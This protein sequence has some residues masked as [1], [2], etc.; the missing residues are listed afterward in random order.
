MDLD[1]KRILLSGATGGL[2]QA[3]AQELADA[4]AELVLSSRREKELQEIAAGL[5]G[6]SHE[7]I[8]ADLSKRGAAVK[9]IADAGDIDGLIA[10]AAMPATGRMEELTEDQ[11][12]RALIV[13]F[14]SPIL[15]THALVPALRKKG[16]GHL[17]YVASLAGHAAS[18]RSSLYS[19]T[20]FG[21]RGYAFGLRS[22][23][24]PDGVGVSVVSPGFV[25]DAG[26]F[27]D[28]GAAPPP[29]MGTT[30]PKKVGS[31]VRKAIERNSVER[32]VAPWRQVRAAKFAGAHPRINAAIMKGSLADRSAKE[33]ADGQVDKR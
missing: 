15:M 28:A 26:M 25:R 23:L 1:G 3:I 30:T 10:N 8:A 33:L 2:G 20:K 31:A 4:G 27:A 19:A 14:D 13:N 29:G 6:G 7:V 32:V 16:E 24:A 12:S 18:P 22:D 9:L 21:L 5:P 17:V 11:V